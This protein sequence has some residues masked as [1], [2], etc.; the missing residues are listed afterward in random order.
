MIESNDVSIGAGG[1]DR[2]IGVWPGGGPGEEGETC[3]AGQP[4][5]TQECRGSP[6]CLG[7]GCRGAIVLK[8]EPGVGQSKNVEE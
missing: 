2:M 3:P 1:T 8:E 4:G 5:A 6:G 7:G